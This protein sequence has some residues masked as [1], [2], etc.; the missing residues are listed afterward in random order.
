M[1]IAYLVKALYTEYIK[2][3]L[4]LNNKKDNPIKRWVK[5]S[6]KYFSKEDIPTVN[7]GKIL[8][9]ISH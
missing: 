8:N 9:L 7:T 3:L 1:Y 6:N 5:V 2:R 4:K